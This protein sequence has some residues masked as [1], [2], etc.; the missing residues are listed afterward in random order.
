MSNFAKILRYQHTSLFDNDSDRLLLLSILIP[1]LVKRRDKRG[2]TIDSFETILFFMSF[3]CFAAL[4][5]YPKVCL[6][7]YVFLKN[8]I[9]VPQQR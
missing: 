6:F 4:F 7:K 2:K 8:N 3:F 1:G 9:Y 5:A